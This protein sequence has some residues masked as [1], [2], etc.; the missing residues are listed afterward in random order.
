M[1][2]YPTKDTCNHA[3]TNFANRQATR[4][5]T[6]DLPGIDLAWHGTGKDWNMPFIVASGADPTHICPEL[7]RRLATIC[8]RP[9]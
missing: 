9:P 5:P 4:S 2:N 8:R 6:A 1:R 7:R 3:T